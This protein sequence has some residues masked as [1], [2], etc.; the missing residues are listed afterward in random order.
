[1]WNDSITAHHSI[2][3]LLSTNSHLR[4]LFKL[5][6]I[7]ITNFEV[8]SLIDATNPKTGLSTTLSSEL[9]SQIYTRKRKDVVQGRYIMINARYY[10]IV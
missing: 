1:M 6:Q 2:S 3:L 8:I 7:A 9:Q 10:E 5:L 4:Q